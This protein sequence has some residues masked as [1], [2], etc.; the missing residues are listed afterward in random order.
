VQAPSLT[1]S[2]TM[3]PCEC[4]MGLGRPVVP[5]EYTTHSGCS[6]GT[7]STCSGALPA[8]AAAQAVRWRTR[9]GRHWHRGRAAGSGGRRWAVRPAVRGSVRGGRAACRRS[10]SHRPRSAPWARSGGSGRA[11]QCAPCRA[12]RRTRSRR[13]WPRRGRRRRLRNVRQVGDDAVAAL[14]A[15]RAQA[16]GQ[17][18]DLALQLGPGQLAIDAGFIAR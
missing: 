17:R 12:S 11:P 14:H 18:A 9:Q 6:K 16:G 4:T 13:G 10:G 3:P 2:T 7:C 5:E 8:M 15:H 1:C